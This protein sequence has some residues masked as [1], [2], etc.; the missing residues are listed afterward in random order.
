MICD[1]P[2]LW[3]LVAWVWNESLSINFGGPVAKP[4]RI[5]ELMSFESESNRST[6]PSVS[7]DKND[8]TASRL[9]VEVGIILHDNHIML[10]GNIVNFFAS[11]IT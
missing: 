2:E 11:I 4:M 9:H 7:S 10:S 8:L 6:L 5:P 3:R 1:T